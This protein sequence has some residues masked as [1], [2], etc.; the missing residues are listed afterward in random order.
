[1]IQPFMALPFASGWLA[2]LKHTGHAAQAGLM[3]RQASVARMALDELAIWVQI[4]LTKR[5][6]F[7]EEP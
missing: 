2:A 6:N 4:P 5:S 7:L 3:R 1:M